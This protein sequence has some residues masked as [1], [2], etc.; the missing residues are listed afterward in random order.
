MKMGRAIVVILVSLMLGYYLWIQNVTSSELV[1]VSSSAQA[2]VRVPR[3]QSQE[4]IDDVERFAE[5]NSLSFTLNKV[6]VRWEIV[7]IE[8][9][10]NG[11]YEINIANATE[12]EKFIVS[13]FSFQEARWQNSWQ[14]FKRHVARRWEWQDVE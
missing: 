13:V 10:H 2:W 8:A 3:E 1:A 4:F 12:E 6:S 11:D 5:N 7:Y 9:T 14:K